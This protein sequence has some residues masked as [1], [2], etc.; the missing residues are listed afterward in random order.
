MVTALLTCLALARDT[1]ITP[2]SLNQPDPWYT[3]LLTPRLEEPE[4]FMAWTS[5]PASRTAP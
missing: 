2:E 1:V 3:W 5:R 4:S